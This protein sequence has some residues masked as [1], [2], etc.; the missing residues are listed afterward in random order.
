MAEPKYDKPFRDYLRDIGSRIRALRDELGLTTEQAAGAADMSPGYWGLVE[1]A[2]KQPSLQSLF[3]FAKALKVDVSDLVNVGAARSTL[4]T[5]AR[6]RRLD[7]ILEE[8]TPEQTKAI[9]VC[10]KAISALK[11]DAGLGKSPRSKEKRG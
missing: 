1:R 8:S 11:A 10:A 4:I 2:A 9:L 5:K 6:G 7:Q 3:K